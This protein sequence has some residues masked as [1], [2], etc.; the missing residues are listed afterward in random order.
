MNRLIFV[1]FGGTMFIKK[2]LFSNDPSYLYTSHVHGH[3]NNFLVISDDRKTLFF[4][5]NSSGMIKELD[6]TLFEKFMKKDENG[7]IQAIGGGFGEGDGNTKPNDD[8]DG[9]TKNELIM[10]QQTFL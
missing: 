2:T 5:E 6:L 3:T 4:Q 10:S 7:N 9:E 8:L 1:E